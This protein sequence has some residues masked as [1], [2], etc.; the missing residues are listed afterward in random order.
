[1]RE[2]VLVVVLVLGGCVYDQERADAFIAAEAGFPTR[3]AGE[4]ALLY[5]PN[6]FLDALDLVHVGLHMGIGIGAELHFTRYG[7]L[8]AIAMVDM[9]VAWL[10]RFTNPVHLGPY[11]RASASVFEAQVFS[12]ERAGCDP[13]RFPRWDIGVHYAGYPI[14]D[15]Y[16]AFAPDELLDFLAGWICYDTKGDDLILENP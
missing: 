3:G 14:G 4:V 9:G 5:L 11:A 15:N 16:V 12:P 7:R 1:M 13:W 8:G 6:R 2:L 10:G